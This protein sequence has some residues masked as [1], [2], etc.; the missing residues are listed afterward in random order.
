[1]KKNNEKII[2]L[3]GAT[4]G[5][6]KLTAF[7]LFENGINLIIHGRNETKLKSLY[8]EL[9]KKSNGNFV[10][11][12]IADF[13]SLDEVRD[14]AR[15]IKLKYNQL[16]VL[17]NNAAAGMA[18]ERYSRDG[19]ELRFAVNFLAP[20]LLTNLLLPELKNASPS[21]IVNVSS[22]GQ[23]PIDFNDIM[24]D[25]SFDET[26]AYRQSKLA[27]IMFTFDLA[28]KL[29]NENITV[30]ALHPGT[31]LD[32]NMVRNY[33]IK[34]LGKAESGADAEVYLAISEKVENVSGKFFNVKTVAQADKQAYDE[35]A[36][37]NIWNVAANL[38]KLN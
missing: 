27:L 25:N 16:D 32:T 21:R 17:I 1:M 4:D 20:F 31:Y 13:S 18:D 3:T 33:D 38:T 29:Q 11:C 5:I 23:H 12:F 37:Q 28:E 2:L 19:Y 24:L 35:S 26:R 36:R 7:K 15:E 14:F 34:P 6:G 22:I 9:V 8:N 10:D 30:N